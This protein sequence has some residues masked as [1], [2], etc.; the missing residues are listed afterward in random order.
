MAKSYSGS[1]REP[2]HQMREKA[3]KSSVLNKQG[4]DYLSHANHAGKEGKMAK[5]GYAQGDMK[6]TIEDFHLP[7]SAF[8]QRGF[9]KTTEY[10]ERNNAHQEMAARELD[11]QEYKGRYN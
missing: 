7:E 9:S 10:Q 2:I 5:H 4:I 11:K 8:S 1:N 6:P 3:D